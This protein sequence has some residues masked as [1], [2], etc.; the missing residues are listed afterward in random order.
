[1][2]DCSLRSCGKPINGNGERVEFE[3][4]IK[5]IV[6]L[7][8]SG[9]SLVKWVIKGKRG[10]GVV[11]YGC[12]KEVCRLLDMPHV[13]LETVNQGTQEQSVALG[14]A[15]ATTSAS[16]PAKPAAAAS[17]RSGRMTRSRARALNNDDGPPAAKQAK[18][19]AFTAKEARAMLEALDTAEFYQDAAIVARMAQSLADKIKRAQH[20]VMFTGAGV[21]TST[22]IGDYRGKSGKWT[23]AATGLED[24]EFE[25]DG[26]NFQELRPSYT[27]EAIAKLFADGYV[28]FLISQNCD[29]LH[30]MSG[31]LREQIAEVHGNIFQEYCSQCKH[32]YE[33]GSYVP[34]DDMDEVLMQQRDL[35]KDTF[36]E[37][38]PTCR[39]NHYTGR[40]CEQPGCSG[41]LRDTII[42]FGDMLRDEII[43]AAQDNAKRSD[44]MI[45][46]GTTLSVTPVCEL[47]HKVKRKQLAI[48]NRQPT[49]K[50]STAKAGRVYGDVDPFMEALMQSLYSAEELQAWQKGRK[51]RMKKYDAMR[52]KT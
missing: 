52:S 22:G 2:P 47:A 15:N 7:I 12:Y 44:L 21:S 16:M 17:I 35:P 31:V 32:E 25:T 26:V 33:R 36:A 5:G 10:L 13:E 29:G 40:V 51:A 48:V 37:V 1:M 41:K 11:H 28:H 3:A 38:C 4:N 20:V 49:E 23:A 19:V 8:K 6:H 45:A 9:K 39:L 50:D 34:D 14:S 30:R 27:H 42:N 43:T 18:R 46:L 24:E